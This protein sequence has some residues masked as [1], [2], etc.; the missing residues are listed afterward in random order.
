MKYSK[1]TV[2]ITLNTAHIGSCTSLYHDTVHTK[3]IFELLWS[4][5]NEKLVIINSFIG[6]LGTIASS[7]RIKLLLFI[8]YLSMA[9]V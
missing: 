2:V 9:E 6:L 3:T 4:V 5:A 7:A 1:I 8:E